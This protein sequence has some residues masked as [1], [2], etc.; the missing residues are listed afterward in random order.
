[1]M[2]IMRDEM[3]DRHAESLEPRRVVKG[4]QEAIVI[5]LL[6]GNFAGDMGEIPADD[7]QA[8]Q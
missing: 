5:A 2:H 6:P 4:V 3:S 7:T 1:M 8:R